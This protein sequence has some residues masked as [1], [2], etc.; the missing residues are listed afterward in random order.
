MRTAYIL[1]TLLIIASAVS[2]VKSNQIELM[3]RGPLDG[4]WVG[5]VNT[6]E[7]GKCTWPGWWDSE[8][9]E[10]E[11]R[12]NL[13]KTNLTVVTKQYSLANELT[14]TFENDTIRVIENR[15]T[16]CNGAQRTYNSLYKGV[17]NGKTITLTSID[18]LCPD[19]GCVTQRTMTL[20]RY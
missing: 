17:V 20:R 6:K 3:P 10:F 4:I 11:A 16:Y 9:R 12:F 18:T 1:T 8:R 2:C 19:Q 15:S 7:V 13:S 5:V 14:G